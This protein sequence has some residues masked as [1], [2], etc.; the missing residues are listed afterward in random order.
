M[1]KLILW[2]LFASFLFSEVQYTKKEIQFLKDNPVIYISAMTYWPLDD[3]GESIHTNYIHLLNKYG[4][5]NIQPVFYRYWSDG[6]SDA[7]N[8][9][10]FGIMALSYSKKRTKWFYYTKPYN[11]NPY[12]LIVKKGS[13][14][15]SLKDL[16][17]KKVYIAKYSILRE[18]LKNKDFNI[19][20]TKTPYEELENN[21]IDAILTFYM[22]NNKY[23]NDFKAIKAFIDKAGEEYIGINK[24]Y[25][26]LYSI[27]KKTMEAI[28]Y[29]E[30]EKIRQIPYQKR[31]K[32]TEVLAPKVTL[33]DLITI[34][35]IILVSLLLI[36]LGI[37]V[38]FLLNRKFL[39]L[40]I[41]QFLITIFVFDI[42]I[43]GFIFYEI[44]VFNYYSNKILEIKSRSFNSLYK[45]DQIEN[46]V[47]KV[48]E[49]FK[50]ALYHKVNNIKQLFE[51]EYPI[52]ENLLVNNKPLK[53]ILTTK[54]FTT[55]ELASLAYSQQLINEILLV[56]K[57][58]LDKRIDKAI[59][60]QK[61]LYLLNELKNVKDIIKNE[62][63]H[64][65]SIIKEKLKYQFL[66][67]LFSIGL[68]IIESILVFIMIKR[69]IYNPIDY[70]IKVIKANKNGKKITNKPFV[71]EDEFGK[72]IDEFFDLQK[73]LN[74]KIDELNEHKQ[75]LE[76][77]VKDEVD[78]RLYQEKILLKKSK[79]AMMG[80]M[81]DAI[82]HQWKQPLT[83]MSLGMQILNLEKDKITPEE[84]D[85]VIKSMNM[86][87]KHML[88]TLDEFRGFFRDD[89]KKTIVCINNVVK[90]VLL[91]LQDEL[92]TN[93]IKIETNI[94]VN[95]C[96]NGIENEIEHL[97]ITLITNAKDIFKE[98][99]IK[100]RKLI[101]QT[102]SDENFYYLE[103]I[104]NAGGVD[105]NIKHKIFELN[106]TTRENGTGVG[107]YL[108]SQIAT[109]HNAVLEVENVEDGA[110]FYFKIKKDID[111]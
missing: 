73:Q 79:M 78:K 83:S 92:M 36:S 90:M 97:L 38:Y 6:F 102:R 75:N 13:D 65:I 25:P 33:K 64:E 84:L 34:Q 54:N 48:D 62:N 17:N 55:T 9:I 49:Y 16:T 96:F 109:K 77:Q 4:H 108:A 27:I 45:V 106:Y 104:D 41:K 68:F 50:R 44:L 3:E 60:R 40:K 57:Q 67:L 93:K 32:V 70:L 37:I 51:N 52:A 29:S 76:Q 107:L 20:Y 22:P 88:T 7:K 8:G 26:I 47:L 21:K 63:K 99:D 69:K 24:K 111:E 66:L 19:V 98:R 28:P 101:I 103:V 39:H 105:E 53:N 35:D 59:Y 46:S 2:V 89:T 58:V 1:K 31:I 100:D 43:L 56:Q 5:L 94:D 12:Y 71:Y 30:I 95:F 10:T 15:H 74:Q 91:L 87:I 80:E 72:L 61:L 82:A 110:K 14:I 11:Y 86:Q 85:D 23:I 42:F 81:V 18:V